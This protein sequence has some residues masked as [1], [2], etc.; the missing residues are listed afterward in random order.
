MEKT[1]IEIND[2]ALSKRYKLRLTGK[3]KASIETTIP[4]EAFEREAKRLGLETVKDAVERLD[5]VW[6]FGNFRG[7]FLSF[8][9]KKEK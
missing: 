1:V 4:T 6:R 7:L 3:N 5:A 2:N 8:E 9:P